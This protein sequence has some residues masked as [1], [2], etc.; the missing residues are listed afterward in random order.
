MYYINHNYLHSQRR[1]PRRGTV[2]RATLTALLDFEFCAA[3]LLTY[4]GNIEFVPITLA[5]PTDDTAFLRSIVILISSLLLFAHNWEGQPMT[6]IVWAVENPAGR[7][8]LAL[9]FWLG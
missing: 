4:L 5:V 6:G 9:L 3:R 1:C 7:L 8:F 2:C